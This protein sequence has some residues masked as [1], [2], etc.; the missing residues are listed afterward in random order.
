MSHHGT[1]H[2]RFETKVQEYF[3]SRSHGESGWHDSVAVEINYQDGHY[4]VKRS[5]DRAQAGMSLDELQE[6]PETELY[7]LNIGSVPA[8]VQYFVATN[9][10]IK[11]VGPRTHMIQPGC[12]LEFGGGPNVF[13]RFSA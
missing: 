12:F 6:V 11:S 10:G 9:D 13:W 8:K 3:Q 1:L 5:P 2:L 4:D 7:V